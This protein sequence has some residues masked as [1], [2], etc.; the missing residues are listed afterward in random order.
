MLVREH[1]SARAAGA[2]VGV[3]LHT[4]G[5]ARQLGSQWNPPMQPQRQFCVGAS[6]GHAKLCPALAES[7]VQGAGLAHVKSSCR[8]CGNRMSFLGHANLICGLASGGRTLLEQAN[9]LSSAEGYRF[10]DFPKLGR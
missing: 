9:V 10:Q 4:W 7:S 1:V 2:T 8:V 3:S 5:V 6:P